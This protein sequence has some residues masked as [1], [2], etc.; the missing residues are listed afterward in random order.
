MLGLDTDWVGKDAVGGL[1]TVGRRGEE[2]KG[3]V[4][5]GWWRNE[6]GG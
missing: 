3:R 4:A 2:G 5:E 6:V 1:V